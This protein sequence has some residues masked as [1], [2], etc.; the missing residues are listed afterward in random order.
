MADDQFNPEPRNRRTQRHGPPAIPHHT[1]VRQIGF[2]S[3]GEIWL[4]LN[5]MG[6]YRAV[7]I[8]Y[9]DSFSDQKPFERE[10]SGIRK[11]EP[12]SRTHEGFIDILQVGFDDAAGCFFYIMELGDDCET[13]T[14]FDPGT[15]RPKTLA[16]EIAAHGRISV[17][18]C[19]QLG[20]DLARAIH[21]LHAHGLVHRD[22]KPSN[23]VFVEGKPKL[24][25]IGMVAGVDDKK[26]YVG[27]EGF[28]PPEGAGTPEADIYSLGKV[29][30]EA[31]T[32]EDRQHF[33][34]LP[35]ALLASPE[36]RSFLELNEIILRACKKDVSERYKSAAEMTADLVVLLDGKSVKRLRHLERSLATVKRIALGTL[37]VAVAGLIVFY[38]FYRNLKERNELRQRDIGSAVAYGNRALEAGDLLGSLPFYAEALRLRHEARAPEYDDRFRLGAVLAQ[39]PKLTHFWTEAAEIVDAQFSPDDSRLVLAESKKGVKIFNLLD[40][41]DPAPAALT[42]T[43]ES[44]EFSPDGRNIVIANGNAAGIFDAA[45]L[46]ETARFNHPG[47]VLSARYSPDGGKLVTACTDGRVRVWDI[48]SG[49]SQVRGTH[50][51]RARYAEFS[52]D[53]KLIASAGDDSTAAIWDAASGRLVCRLSHPTWV[54]DVSFSPDDSEVVTACLDGR[55]RVWG[56][57]GVQRL[58]EMIHDDAVAS[59]GFSPDGRWILTASIDGT[60]RIWQHGTLLPIPLNHTLRNGDRVRHASFSADGSQIVLGGESGAVDVWSLAGQACPPQPVRSVPSGDGQRLMTCVDGEVSVADMATGA[61]SGSPIRFDSR[62]ELMRLNNNGQVGAVVQPAESKNCFIATLFDVE[63]PQTLKTEFEI[64]TN[65]WAIC[66][67]QDGRHGAVLAGD[68]VRIVD[69]PTGIVV[70]K[71]LPVADYE[72]GILDWQGSRLITWSQDSTFIHVWSLATVTECYPPLKMATYVTDVQLSPD[73]TKLLAS[74]SDSTLAPCYATEWNLATGRETGAHMNHRDGVLSARYSPDGTKI[75]T[76]GEDYVAS[77]WDA[78]TQHRQLWGIRHHGQ[79]ADVSF[80]LNATAFVTGSR[81]GIAR[82]W[83]TATGDPLSPA[84]YHLARIRKTMLLGDGSRLWVDTAGGNDYVWTVNPDYQPVEDIRLIADILSGE[85]SEEQGGSTPKRSALL[86]SDWARLRRLYPATFSTSAADV[87]SWHA[88]VAQECESRNDSYGAAYH[89]K[90]LT[91]T[92]D[93]NAA[94]RLN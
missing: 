9:R 1:L 64:R 16:S 43:A 80:N 34:E 30:Y 48:A 27:T 59:A 56:T 36:G 52:H 61:H 3:Y 94:A 14:A 51:N 75:G 50:S 84:F 11:F 7:K 73:G 81:D 25:D 86:Q 15:Y 24:A 17:D 82:I 88:Y 92:G 85:T 71:H 40:G 91:R 74:C 28:I 10:L 37:A 2:G 22:I 41:S 77:V 55:A 8:V 87:Q 32:G 72:S 89:L 38:P 29:L 68:L 93:T 62:L 18:H 60:A 39:C 45:S 19:L 46:K 54:T 57:N 4:A 49:A 63:H 33:P 31:S 20:A 21:Q 76:G 78:S 35:A 23:I 65:R 66:L 42:N 67:D 6:V 83:S 90:I 5:S 58:P 53:G 26:S 12:I 44:V 70:A 69:L 13:K 79:V 47:L